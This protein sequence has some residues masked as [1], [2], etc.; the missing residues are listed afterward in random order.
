MAKKLNIDLT[1]RPS[2][3][4]RDHYYKITECYEKYGKNI[5]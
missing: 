3:I 1:L 5:K 4:S 2:Q